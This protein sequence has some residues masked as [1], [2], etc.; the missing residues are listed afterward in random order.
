MMSIDT[1]KDT[2]TRD[3]RNHEVSR[4]DSMV[5]TS[6]SI[7]ENNEMLC[8]PLSSSNEWSRNATIMRCAMLRRRNRVMALLES[9]KPRELGSECRWPDEHSSRI[10]WRRWRNVD[11]G[12]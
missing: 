8:R 2:K 9:R 3:Q 12:T 1:D 6:C 7:V 5:H 10:N 4:N 11:G